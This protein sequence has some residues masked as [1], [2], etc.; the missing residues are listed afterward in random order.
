[1]IFARVELA[2]ACILILPVA[3]LAH[4]V[5][6]VLAFKDLGRDVKLRYENKYIVVGEAADYITLKKGQYAY[7]LACGILAGFIPIIIFGLYIHPLLYIFIAPYLFGCK[8]DI[9][10]LWRL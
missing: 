2:L 9:K 7:V 5:G 10:N 8:E 1:M 4:E 6:H 3:V